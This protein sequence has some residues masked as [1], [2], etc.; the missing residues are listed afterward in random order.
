MNNPS[1]Y[2]LAQPIKGAGGQTGSWRTSRPVFY[3][4]KCNGCLL[5]WIFCPEGV[6]AK[7]D[8]TIDYDYC[9]GC[10]ICEAECSKQAIIMVKEEGK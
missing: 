8:R 10:G 4:E 1:I 3:P 5:C 2:P 7:E 9:K 6:I